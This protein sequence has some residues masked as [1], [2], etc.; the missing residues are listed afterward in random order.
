MWM[1]ERGVLSR[2][3]SSPS[4]RLMSFRQSLLD[5]SNE[6]PRDLPFRSWETPEMIWE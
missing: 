2:G 5:S 1:D 6:A 3:R 4:M